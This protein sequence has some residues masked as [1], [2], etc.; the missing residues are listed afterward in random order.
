MIDRLTSDL[1]KH[2]RSKNLVLK[3]NIKND[4]I[5]E[6]L[7]ANSNQS[8]KTV[9]FICY[10]GVNT[11]L[12]DYIEDARKQNPPIIIFENANKK[13]IDDVNWILVSNARKAWSHSCSFING[14]PEKHLEITGITGTNGKTS[15]IF[16][17]GELF[18]I[19]NI[20]RLTVGTLG[21][22]LNGHITESN[23]TTPDPDVLY[24]ILLK[25]KESGIRH[26][27]MEV[28]SH[29]IIQHKIDPINFKVYGFT[30][31]SQDH[32]DFHK[33]MTDYLEAK[34]KPITRNL[35]NDSQIVISS[36]VINEY[37]PNGLD[38]IT[39]N[40]VIKIGSNEDDEVFFSVNNMTISLRGHK[41]F[42]TPLL[43]EYSNQ[44]LMMSLHICQVLTKKPIAALLD[45]IANIKQVPGRLEIVAKS[46]VVI[47][48]YAHTP[49]A[50]HN[51]LSTVFSNFNQPIISILGC[52]GDRDQ[53][54]RPLMGQIAEKL[55]THVIIT[56]DNPRSENPNSI[57]RQIVGGFTNPSTSFLVELDRYEA[58]KK[59]IYL[60]NLYQ[61]ILVIA[62]KGHETTQLIGDNSISFDDREVAKE[63][64]ANN[65]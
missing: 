44:N 50:L 31:F 6:N 57:A 51:V 40:P 35:N 23:H 7:T 30:S 41:K 24:P 2:L 26:V 22:D 48:D 9:G 43:G 49:D 17:L 59:G 20:P 33:T 54:K 4:R 34:L 37:I 12:H 3:A 10:K 5:I 61:C 47:V 63:I 32:L 56:N 55:S 28:S 38:M 53:S 25:A 42:E 65:R 21:F 14:L 15:T 27:F 64:L 13:P 60:A 11:D 58:I 1:L 18:R 46:P 36:K 29:A 39:H 62:G 8:A 45:N 52:G 19:L 16:I